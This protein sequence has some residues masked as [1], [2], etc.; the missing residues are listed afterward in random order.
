M[1]RPAPTDSA[2]TIQ[3][4]NASLPA[5]PGASGPVYARI[6]TLGGGGT[7]KLSTT[8]MAQAIRMAA[9]CPANVRARLGPASS[10]VLIV[11]RPQS[12][13]A[14]TAARTMKGTGG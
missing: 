8:L 14:M 9:A 6:A 10:A 13:P 11:P 12:P 5:A 1:S 4:G 3:G 2:V 7:P